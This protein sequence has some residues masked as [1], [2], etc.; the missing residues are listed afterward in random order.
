MSESETDRLASEGLAVSPNLSAVLSREALLDAL[1]MIL[2]GTSLP[3]VLSSIA[4]LIE[5]HSEG[6]LCSIF[7]ADKDG[8]SLRYAAAPNLPVAYR[9]ATDGTETGPG[10]G[11]CSM[12]AYRREPV[13][14]ADFP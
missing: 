2:T 5:G 13:F 10:R 8:L 6:M 4:L 12:A 11:P 14:V 9:T 1:E 7:L 3:N